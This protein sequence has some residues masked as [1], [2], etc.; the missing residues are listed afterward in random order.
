MLFN[1]FIDENG[2]GVRQ[3]SE[4]PAP[5]VG[6]TGG[7]QRGIVTG[8]D[9]RVLVT[10]LGS[11]PT[12]H[13]DVSLDKLDNASVSAPPSKVQLRPRAGSV[14]R[15]DYPLRPTGGVAVKIELL[16]DDG[17]RIGL[18]SVRVQLVPA[19]GDASRGVPV[20]G[21]TE[22]DGAAIFDAVPIGTYRLQLDP[23]QAERL[24]MRLLEAPTV[25]IKGDGAFTP[26]L[27]VQVRFEPAP[28]ETVVAK[29]GGR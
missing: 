5:D 6:L 12:A 18:S 22:F 4:A 8:R 11:G 20:D 21:V 1:A 27:T 19:G 25:V 14:T 7:P 26:D 24:R 17:K 28:P 15:V 29:S 16:R 10:G 3:A 13:M 23:R 9:G 2:D